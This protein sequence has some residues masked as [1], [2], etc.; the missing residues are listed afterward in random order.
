MRQELLEFAELKGQDM[1]C[2]ASLMTCAVCISGVL[3]AAEGVLNAAEGVLNAATGVYLGFI[4]FLKFL[5]VF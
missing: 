3:N 4:S 5:L 1:E 2:F